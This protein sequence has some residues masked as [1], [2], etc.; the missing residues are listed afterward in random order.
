MNYKLATK[1]DLPRVV[2]FFQLV[3]KDF[4]PYLSK[5]FDIEKNLYS[6]F[7][8]DEKI[9]ILE[10]IKRIL[11][12]ICFSID[13]NKKNC[14]HISYL[15]IHPSHRNKLLGRN[16]LN[17]CL[18]ILIGNKVSK[19]FIE[20]WSTNKE[21]LDLYDKKGFVIKKIINNDRGEGLDTIVLEEPIA[22]IKTFKK[23]EK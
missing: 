4:I 8:H 13:Q 23:K 22:G 2:N 9:L 10:K 3:D 14:A 19:V 6:L 12:V 16:L 17:E 5:R 15:A 11:W 18:N 21:A 20:T 7:E 1:K